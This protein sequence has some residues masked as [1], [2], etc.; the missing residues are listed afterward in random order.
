M[1]KI[2]FMQLFDLSDLLTAHP[3]IWQ[4]LWLS[5]FTKVFAAEL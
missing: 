5:V 3:I 2:S 1:Q 4:A